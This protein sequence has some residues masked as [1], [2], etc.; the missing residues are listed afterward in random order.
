MVKTHGASLYVANSTRLNAHE[1]LALRKV[2]AGKLG[3]VRRAVRENARLRKEPNKRRLVGQE[4]VLRVQTALWASENG[5]S[6][7]R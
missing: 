2:E 5:R 7:C 6:V 4:E 1:L 3:T